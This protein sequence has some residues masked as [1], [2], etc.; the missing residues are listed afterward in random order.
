MVG[1]VKATVSV[2]GGSGS[3]FFVCG[4]CFLLMLLWLAFGMWC[5]IGGW[6]FMLVGILR[7][8]QLFLC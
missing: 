3:G 1:L 4:W 7:V 2:W 5:L 8:F 6:L